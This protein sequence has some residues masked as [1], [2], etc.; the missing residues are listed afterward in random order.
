MWRFQINN[1]LETTLSEIQNVVVHFV[2]NKVKEE[3]LQLSNSPSGMDNPTLKVLWKYI[4]SAFT[5][6]DFF[7]FT[8]PVELEMN[9]VFKL[10]K[11]CFANPENFMEH[12]KSFAKLLYSVSNHPKVKSGEFFVIYFK[13]LGTSKIEADAIGLF[14]SEKKQPFLLTE[15][16][17]NIIDVY[18]HKGINP[19]KV[20]KACL[21]FNSDAESGYQVLAVD[22]VNKGEEAKFWFEDFLKIKTRSTEYSKTTAMIG[23][24]KSFIEHEPIIQETFD[25][26]DNINMLNRS[27][28]YFKGNEAFDQN[29]FSDEVFN[30]EAIKNRFLEFT[31]E[32][33]SE[34]LSFADAFPISA[35]AVKKKQRVFKSVLK[36][37]K[38]FHVYIHGNRELIEQGTDENGKKFYKL[39]Y[40]EES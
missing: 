30:D 23:L 20:D 24:T 5:A 10:A 26:A 11:K 19:G 35:E 15:E 3:E 25:R 38:N 16:A 21:I 28:D 36:L 17:N 39:Y 14:K 27:L 29:T 31:K 40:E 2:G 34:D 6:P 33:E 13:R 37:D 18:S 9:P 1:M 8:H 7:Q 22:N 4:T 12:S 32:R